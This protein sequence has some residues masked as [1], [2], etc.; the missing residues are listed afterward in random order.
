MIR[1]VLLLGALAA[2]SPAFADCDHFKWSVAK[3]REAFATPQPLTAVSDSAKVG[4]AYALTL[5]QGVDLPNIPERDPKPGKYSAVVNLGDLDAGLYQISVSQDVWIDVAQ[6]GKTVKSSDFS[7]Q[8]DCPAIR[9]SVRFKLGAGPATVEIL[10]AD[11]SAL[12]FA[13]EPAP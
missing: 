5:A 9:K 8:H 3:E 10:N 2:A 13:I 12:N 6:A 4:Q 11:A 1:S 7:G